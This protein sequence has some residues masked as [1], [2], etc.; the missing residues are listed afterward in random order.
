MDVRIDVSTRDVVLA[1]W[2][3]VVLALFRGR[4]TVQALRRAGQLVP[5]LHASSKE[6]VFMLTVVEEQASLPALEVRMELVSFLKGVNGQ[7]DRSAVVFEGEGF[8]A[9]SVRAVVAGVS[10]FSRPDY[11][12]RVFGSV[13]SAARFLS[14]GRQGV[15]VP[16]RVIRMVQEARRAPGTQTFLPWMHGVPSTASLRPR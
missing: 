12:H 15:L 13:G 3:R 1:V 2:D 11:P 9:A 10:L 5:E 16:H 8:R 6:L 14:G 4:T 7:V